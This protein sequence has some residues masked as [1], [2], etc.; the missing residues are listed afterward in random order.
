MRTHPAGWLH[1]QPLPGPPLCSRHTLPPTRQHSPPRGWGALR[2]PKAKREPEKAASPFRR[3]DGNDPV[4]AVGRDGLVVQ[5]PDPASGCR[6]A[7][8]AV[9]G[10]APAR[11]WVLR[12]GLRGTGIKKATLGHT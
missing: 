1:A 5:G 6:R 4:G 12:A 3:A 10:A 11:S 2:A 7:H 9:A 8:R